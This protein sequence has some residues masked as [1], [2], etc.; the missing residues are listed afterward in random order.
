MLRK[1]VLLA[2]APLYLYILKAV[3]DFITRDLEV[4]DAR[5]SQLDPSSLE[6]RKLE[7]HRL[8]LDQLI[9]LLCSAE[10]HLTP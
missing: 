1:L 4:R 5:L 6:H 8:T 7:L 10:A 9:E 2:L 3:S